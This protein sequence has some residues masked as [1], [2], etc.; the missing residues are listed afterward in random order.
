MNVN[1]E[2]S[3]VIRII[4]DKHKKITAEEIR[5]EHK[6]LK[7]VN[8]LKYPSVLSV[9][10]NNTILK[11]SGSFS[12]N[13]SSC[14]VFRVD[15][16]DQILAWPI[17]SSGKWCGEGWGEMDPVR[18]HK[19]DDSDSSSSSKSH[20]HS[21]YNDEKRYSDSDLSMDVAAGLYDD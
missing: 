12:N 19:D 6:S 1:S 4:K 9:K 11:V 8:N 2:S 3:I 20:G 7:L 16:I 17:D 13:D 21:R 5:P 10:K 18:R 14:D 15:K